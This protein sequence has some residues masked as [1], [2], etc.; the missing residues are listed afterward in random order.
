MVEV[1]Q[2]VEIF[3]SNKEVFDEDEIQDLNEELAK[4]EINCKVLQQ[5]CSDGETLIFRK[6]EI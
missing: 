1:K 4:M 5:C 3:R 6:T 2:S